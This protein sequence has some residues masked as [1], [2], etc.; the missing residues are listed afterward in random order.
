MRTLPPFD[1]PFLLLLVGVDGPPSWYI[2]G[3]VGGETISWYYNEIATSTTPQEWGWHDLD[4][5]RAWTN[6]TLQYP[7]ILT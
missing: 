4:L 3:G 6:V 1:C 7:T 5:I 2:V